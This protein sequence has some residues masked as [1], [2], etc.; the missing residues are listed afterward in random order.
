[1]SPQQL[2]LRLL[3]SRIAGGPGRRLLRRR[4][5]RVEAGEGSGLRM[6]LPQNHDY[7][8]GTSEIPVQ[9][10]LN[11]HLRPGD[12]FFDVGANVGFFSLIAARLVRPTGAVC[13]FEPVTE[14]AAAVRQNAVLN[15]LANVRVFETALGNAPGVA[16]FLLTEWDGGGT[17]ANSAVRPTDPVSRRRVS[18]AVLDDLMD[19]LSLPQPS[20]V[21]IDVEGVEMQVL[22]GM[23]RTIDE[24]MPALLYEVDDGNR[25]TFERRWQELDDFAVSRGYQVSRLKSSYPNTGW[26]VG[27]SLALPP[28]ARMRS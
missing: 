14:N 4:T 23:A 13:C 25:E 18:V 3:S 5:W 16:E 21:K 15:D 1:M 24:S 20:F 8:R 7:L 17:L 11:A 19:S 12:V 22:E 6:V 9:R 28:A 26:F 10:A 2:L 27:H